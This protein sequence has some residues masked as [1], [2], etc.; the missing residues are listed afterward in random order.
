MIAGEVTETAR[1][2]SADGF[3]PYLVAVLAARLLIVIADP[4]HLLYEKANKFLH[5]G[6]QWDVAKL[7]SYWVDKIILKP[8]TYDETHYQEATW[9]LDALIEGLRTPSVCIGLSR[10]VCHTYKSLGFRAVSRLQHLRTASLFLRIA[11]ITAILLPKDPR[12]PLP[13]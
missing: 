5:K 13:L 2:T 4:L 7:P 10:I 8:P 6:P 1:D 9:L 12:S 3:L 11:S